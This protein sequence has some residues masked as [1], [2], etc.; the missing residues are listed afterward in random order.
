MYTPER[1]ITNRGLLI[2]FANRNL[3]RIYLWPSFFLTNKSSQRYRLYIIFSTIRRFIFLPLSSF[4][5]K[6][7]FL[8]ISPISPFCLFFFL[9][10]Y[11]PK[12]L[13]SL[14]SKIFRAC[15]GK[16][17]GPIILR[18]LIASLSG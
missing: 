10:H 1:S 8:F 6:T 9:N 15:K 17:I 13:S 2:I 5:G 18:I 14:Y 16:K 7:I 11:S 12:I 4:F 3:R